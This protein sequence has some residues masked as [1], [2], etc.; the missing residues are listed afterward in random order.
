[1]KKLILTSLFLPL[2]YTASFAQDT[3]KLGFGYAN[4]RYNTNPLESLE[5]TNGFELSAEGTE[6]NFNKFRLSGVVTFQNEFKNPIDVYGFGQKL[7][8]GI[9]KG[10]VIE[11]FVEFTINLETEYEGHNTV[12]RTLAYGADLNFGNFYFRPLKVKERRSGE[13]FSPSTRT[14]VVGAGFRF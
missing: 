5:Y 10:R 4:N 7:S 13:L 8:Y 3:F 6:F 11:P 1:M 9:G 12:S 2:M 14:F